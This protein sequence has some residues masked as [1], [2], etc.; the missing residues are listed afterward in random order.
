MYKNYQNE[1]KFSYVVIKDK[2]YIKTKFEPN[3]AIFQGFQ[4][5]GIL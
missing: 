1:T 3:F 5:I 2:T 4:E